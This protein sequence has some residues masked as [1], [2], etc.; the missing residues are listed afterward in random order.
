MFIASR[1]FLDIEDRLKDLL[2]V[3]IEARDNAEDIE[4]YVTKGLA[5]RVQNRKLRGKISPELKQ[6]IKDLLLRNANGM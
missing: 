2:H 6:L 5:L 4:N 3:C 1:H